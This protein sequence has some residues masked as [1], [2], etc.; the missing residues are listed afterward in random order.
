M[1]ERQ[2]EAVVQAQVEDGGARLADIPVLLFVRGLALVT[3]LVSLVLGL[4]W[5]IGHALV[6]GSGFGPGVRSVM[7]GG[8][9]ASFTSI[10][11]SF[12]GGRVFPRPVAKAAQ[13]VGFVWM[14][15]FGLL[16]TGVAVTDLGLWALSQAGIAVQSLTPWRPAAVMSVVVPAMAWGAYIARR[17]RLVRLEVRIPGLAKGFDGYRLVQ[18]SDVHIGDTL[19]RSFA[20]SLVRRVNALEPD[21]EAITGDMI[22]GS[23]RKLRDEVAPF[24]DFRAK[25]GVY[26]VTGNHE[27]YHGPRAWEAEARR[28]GMTVLHNEH[29]VLTRGADQL[30]IGGVPDLE[31]A[32]FDEAGGPSA[33][34]AFAEAPEGAAR[35]LLAHQP[36]FARDAVGQGVGL[37]LSGHTHAGQ[38]FP[39]VFFVRLQQPV[40]AGLASI[41][42]VQT[43]TSSG[44]GYWGPPF[45]VGTR[46]EITE[47]TLRSGS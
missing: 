11:M 5:Y 3:L 24:A 29:R 19:G 31:S 32:R 17:P 45:R 7:W 30:V 34:L 46:G 13:W 14:G 12:I 4:H 47:L 9:W 15:A 43:Y 6:D 27:Y 26:F 2:P 1:E 36:R 33:H 8:L 21:A 25:D 16:L 42:G 44:T 23:P 28:L 22:D 35:V 18:L 10:P 37:M 38:I 40:I 20:E 41:A 39:F